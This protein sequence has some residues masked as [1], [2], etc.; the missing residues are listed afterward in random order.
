MKPTVYRWQRPALPDAHIVHGIAIS[1]ML[2]VV[3]FGMAVGAPAAASAGE[4]DAAAFM[5]FTGAPLCGLGVFL[6]G[7]FVVVR[8][9]RQA[10][11]EAAIRAGEAEP[12]TK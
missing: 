8:E 2:A 12:V 1:V 10:A 5:A 6:A 4:T 3:G 9:V 7:I 11:F